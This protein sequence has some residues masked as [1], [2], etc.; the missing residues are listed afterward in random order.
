MQVAGGT[1]TQRETETE[2]VSEL[3]L[4]WSAERVG[5]SEDTGAGSCGHTDTETETEAVSVLVLVLVG[6]ESW[7][8]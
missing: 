1:Q 7:K 2:A 3:V 4:L 6:G 5:K 8:K